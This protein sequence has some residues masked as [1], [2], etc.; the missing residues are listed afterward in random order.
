MSQGVRWVAAACAVGLC[1]GAELAAATTEDPPSPFGR[2]ARRRADAREG[3]IRTSDGG[4]H[5]GRVYLI[6]GR[7]Y[8]IWLADEKRF[9]DVPPQVVASVVQEP[10]EEHMER[11]WR[12]KEHAS[13]EK[14]YT[15][16]AYPWRRYRTVLT[17]KDS[18]RE[19]AGEASGVVY[20]E[21]A[22][23]DARKF[24]LY[25]RQKG[26]YGDKLEDLVYVRRIE[27]GAEAVERARK[28]LEKRAEDEADPEGADEG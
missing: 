28:E 2:P 6:R 3:V 17:I 1:V 26:D 7:K 20:L 5:V 14:L 4:I 18:D 15:G 27:Y 21:P 13:D 25:V 11:E 8:R 22:E 9:A 19:L 24:F 10:V 12:W 16:R 23:G